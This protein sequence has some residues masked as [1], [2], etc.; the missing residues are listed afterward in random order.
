[1]ANQILLG[2]ALDANGYIA[3]G[4]KCTVYAAGTSTLI[5]V[6]QDV[7]GTVTAANPII[8]D[9]DGFWAQ[10]FV[11]QAAKAVVTDAADVALYTLD[12]APLSQG[13]GAAASAISFEPTVEVPQDNVQDAIE[14][15]AASV[16]SGFAT[17]GLGITGNATLLSNLDA[18]G[19]GAGTYRFDG[20]TTGTFPTGVAAADTGLVEYWRQSS[21]TA[22]QFLFHATTDRVFHRRMSSTTWG[23]WREVI[24]SNQAPVEG[25]ILYRA[26]SS[27]TRL[28]KGTA[29]QLLRMNTGATAPEWGPL[30]LGV[31]QTWQDFTG[32]GRVRGTSYQNTTGRPIMVS[33]SVDGGGTPAVF[34]VSVDNTTWVQVGNTSTQ[35]GSF[36]II[37]PASSYYRATGSDNLG[38]WSELR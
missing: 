2:R 28:A 26:A 36:N 20:T 1:M 21:A 23:T 3:P 5:P 13:T 25:D 14:A 32:G 7:D 16:I 8:A 11:S 24:T 6:Y 33:V 15:V 19:T 35:W 10:R 30:P 38:N 34:E 31:G 22:M 18:T 9:G 4:A 12:P 29:G 27:W 37:V 17:F